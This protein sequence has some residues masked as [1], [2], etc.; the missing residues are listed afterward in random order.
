M[1]KKPLV[2]RNIAYCAILEEMCFI[3]PFPRVARDL[4]RE[5]SKT[6]KKKKKII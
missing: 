4:R 6:K 3:E 1:R 2:I 5:T